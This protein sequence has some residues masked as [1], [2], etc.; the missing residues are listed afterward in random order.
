MAALWTYTDQQAIKPISANFPQAQF[1][2]LQYEVQVEDLQKLLGFDFYQDMIQNPT[3]TANAALLNGGTYTYN[4]VTY[5]YAGL[6]YTLAYFLFARYVKV[7]SYNDTYGGFVEKNFEDSRRLNAGDEGNLSKDFKIISF[8]YW[9]ENE[10]FIIA[11]S[12]DYPYY[13][14]D[15]LPRRCWDS[16]SYNRS[17][18]F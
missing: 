7:S 4:G 16:V 8:K 18:C 17:F 14:S 5:T 15:P 6:K 9:E 3:S 10:K 1:T 12:S 11:N 13:Y 2:Q